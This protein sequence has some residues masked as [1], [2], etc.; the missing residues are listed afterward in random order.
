MIDKLFIKYC[1]WENERSETLTKQ[2]KYQMKIIHISI[3]Y[4]HPFLICNILI[5]INEHL[6]LLLL[7]DR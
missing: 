7:N 4:Q 2:N 6:L 3:A 1:I 5:S